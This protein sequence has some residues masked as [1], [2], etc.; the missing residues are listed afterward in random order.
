MHQDDHGRARLGR[1]D[2]LTN[3]EELHGYHLLPAA[4]ADLL[5]R[6]GR[7]T[8]AAAA[9]HDALDLVG[10]EPE[11]ATLARRLADR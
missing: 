11:R 3:A 2:D 1:L 9:Y 4:R 5:R 6:M 7:T 8:E 10:N